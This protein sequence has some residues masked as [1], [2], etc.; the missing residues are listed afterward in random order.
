MTPDQLF[1][2]LNLVAIVGW[3]ALLLLPRWRG[4]PTVSGVAVPGLLAGI[5]TWLLVTTWLHSSG[6]FTTLEGVAMLFADRWVLLAGWT[7][8]LVFDLLV[9]TWEFRDARARGLG[10]LW[11]MPCLGLTFLVGPAG[12]LLYLAVSRFASPVRA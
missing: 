8:Y 9:G 2:V 12:W 1:P 4:T 11:L 5:Y 7:H 3:L 10:H 6:G